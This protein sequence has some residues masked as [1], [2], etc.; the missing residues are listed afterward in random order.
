M[1]IDIIKWDVIKKRIKEEE[2]AEKF[3]NEKL[4]S[5]DSFI[6][7]YFD[8]A[9]RITGWFHH[10]NCE[11]CHGRL[12]FNIENSK[13]HVC[14]VC[15]HVN[16][17]ETFTKVWYNT[18]RGRANASVY[19]SGIMYRLTGDEK[20]IKHMKRILSFYADNY[21]DFVSEP[22][23]KRFEGKLQNQHLDDASAVMNMLLGIDMA[24][25]MFTDIE[26]KNYYE[27]LFKREAE[28]FDFF[29]NRIYNIPVW[30]KCAQAAVGAFFN[31]KEHIEKGFYSVYG[32]LDQL[33]KGVTD[34]GMWYEGSMHYH[35]Y[36]IQPI[37]MLMFIC[38]R[39]DFNIPEMGYIYDKIEKMFEYPLTMM[40]SNKRMPNPHDA[41][42]YIDIFNFRTQYEYASI[43]YDNPLFGKVCSL[44]WEGDVKPTFTRLLFNT[45][46]NEAYDINFGT[47][48]NP[49]S[50]TAMLRKGGTELFFRYSTLTHLHRHPDEMSFELAFDGDVVSYDIGNGGYASSLFVEWQRKTLCHNTV[51]I[52]ESDHMRMSLPFGVAEDFDEKESYIK[53]KTKALY[54]ATDFTRSFKVDKNM[55]K[56]DFLV[57]SWDTHLVDWFFYCEGDLVCEYDTKEVE[58]LAPDYL[59]SGKPDP[60][61]RQ[62]PKQAGYQHL[63]EVKKFETDEDWTVNFELPDKTIKVSMAGEPGTTVHLVNS[64]T[65]NKEKTR[66]GIMVRRQADKTLFTTTY[67]CIYK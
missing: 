45:Y 46:E 52:G 3:I 62:A 12:I 61:G 15:S 13:E 66:R 5:L 64:P 51:V 59:K 54:E 4:I 36:T 63:L 18:Y 19:E 65:A 31:E 53:V 9:S 33:K 67:E 28:M 29:A 41:H 38:R 57:H 43:I 24:R 48:N 8:E 2:W 34:E 26:L 49:S 23:A 6:E 7:N 60:H 27:K 21:D 32:I 47:V 14:S 22:I 30:I 17:S 20:Y 25:E 39:V 42:P 40:F 35:F 10:Y 58:T 44:F 50:G 1:M 55:V 56:D 16:S 37:A 11:K